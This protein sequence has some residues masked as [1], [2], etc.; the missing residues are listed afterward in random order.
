MGAHLTAHSSL[1]SCNVNLAH[2]H[3]G[4]KST[5]SHITTLGHCFRQNTRSDLPTDTPFVFAPA[6]LAFES[7]VID[8]SVPILICFILIFG[9]DMERESFTSLTFSNC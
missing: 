4:I 8:D 7:A 2:W 1:N 3:H 9:G 5:L 6:A